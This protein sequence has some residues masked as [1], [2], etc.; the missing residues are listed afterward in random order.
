MVNFCFKFTVFRELENALWIKK[1]EVDR[2]HFFVNILRGYDTTV[3]FSI[4]VAFS[5]LL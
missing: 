2:Q 1:L 3:N 5:S 4:Y